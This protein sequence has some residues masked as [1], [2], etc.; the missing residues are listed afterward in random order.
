[1]T[2]MEAKSQKMRNALLFAV[3]IHLLLVPFVIFVV[4][5]AV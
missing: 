3:P 5:V 1:M 2:R 4:L